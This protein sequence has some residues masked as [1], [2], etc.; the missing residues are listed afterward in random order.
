MNDIP[1]CPNNENTIMFADDTDIF[2]QEKYCK[3]LFSISK[4]E[5][6]N[7]DSLLNTN[8]LTLNVN[9]TNSIAFHTPNNQASSNNLSLYIRN[10]I[11]KRVNSTKLLGVTIH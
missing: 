5:L 9:K 4:Q 3:S 10:N 1:K 7:I 11:V 2:F 6:E 8:K